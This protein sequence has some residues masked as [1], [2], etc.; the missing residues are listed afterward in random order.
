METKLKISI[1]NLGKVVSAETRLKLSLASKN[2][3]ISEESKI[4][5]A[6]SKLGKKWINNGNIQTYV[7]Q[8]ELESFINNGWK[9]GM[10]KSNK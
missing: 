3:V 9:L 4:K 5:I 6:N 8:N 7:T 1:G 10:I 2:K